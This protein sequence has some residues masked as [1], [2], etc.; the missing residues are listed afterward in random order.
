MSFTSSQKP[1]NVNFRIQIL[2][3]RSYACHHDVNKIGTN[4]NKQF[5]DHYILYIL[6]CFIHHSV[7]LKKK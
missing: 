2:D 1:R 4:F 5:I 3:V 6:E 7:K